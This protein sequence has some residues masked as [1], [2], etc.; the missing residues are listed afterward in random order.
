MSSPR[1][2]SSIRVWRRSG[3]VTVGRWRQQV[4]I[5]E[6]PDDPRDELGQLLG[7]RPGDPGELTIVETGQ[8]PLEPG[9]NRGVGVAGSPRP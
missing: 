4:E 6:P 1:I 9:G 5:V 2:D 8:E 3:S 7:A